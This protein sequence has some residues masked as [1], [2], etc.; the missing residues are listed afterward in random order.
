MIVSFKTVQLEM[1][2]SE[3]SAHT[4]VIENKELFRNAVTSFLTENEDEF[5]VFYNNF[6]VCNFSDIGIYL[7]QPIMPDAANKKLMLKVNSYVEKTVDSEF[8][9]EKA[10]VNSAI[11][12]LANNIFQRL[13]FD[14]DYSYEASTKELVKLLNFKIPEDI[15]NHVDY[16]VEY[17]KLVAKYLVCKIVVVNSMHMYFS[18]SEIEE[19]LKT[20]G[21]YGVRILIIESAAPSVKSSFEQIHIIDN[22]L[23]CIDSP[24][25]R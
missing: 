4:L 17:I 25:I 23:C 5:F 3:S 10:A 11:A 14:F 8:S 9:L 13:D 22:D 16:F 18:S 19:I 20:L 21:L 24:N 6:K 15:C 2:F 12:E 1:N 7:N